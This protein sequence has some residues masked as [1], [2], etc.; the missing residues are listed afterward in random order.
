MYIIQ[1]KKGDGW[2]NLKRSYDDLD[3]AKPKLE[4][5]KKCSKRYE[6]R[7]IKINVEIIE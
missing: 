7:L 4:L 2:K 3:I 6:Y 5:L 1:E